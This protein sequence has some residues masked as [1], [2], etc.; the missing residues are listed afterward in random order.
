M[1]PE[2]LTTALHYANAGIP[3]FPC[4]PNKAPATASGFKD[5]TTYPEQIRNWFESGDYLLGIPTG[6]IGCIDV[7]D[8]P[9]AEAFEGELF[10]AKIHALVRQKTPSGG[11]HFLFKS[12]GEPIKNMK[13]ARAKEGGKSGLL[14]ET[15]GIGGYICTGGGYEWERGDLTQLT[16]L[17]SEQLEDVLSAARSFDKLPKEKKPSLKMHDDTTPG[18]DYNRRGDWQSLLMSHGW[19]QAGG[20]RWRRPGKASGVSADWIPDANIFHVFSS[21]AEPLEGGNSYSPFALFTFLE[22]NGNFSEAAKELARQGYGSR[23][24]QDIGKSIDADQKVP[25]AIYYETKS[26]R[27]WIEDSKGRFRSYPERHAV[28]VLQAAGF[29]RAKDIDEITPVLF[30]ARC[31][32]PFDLALNISGMPKGLHQINSLDIL[33]PEGARL[34]EPSPGT[35]KTLETVFRNALEE[36]QWK[37]FYWWTA[38][39]L[40]GLYAG[41]WVPAQVIAL[42]GETGACKSLTQQI[43]TRMFGGSE[44]RII[45]G[46]TGATS[47]NGDWATAT[48]L[49]VEDDFSDNSKS[50]RQR[51]KETVKA[52]AVNEYHRI[53]PKGAQA[54]S[55]R[56]FW[57]MTLSCNPVEESLA[58]LPEIDESVAGKLSLLWCRRASMPMPTDSPPA[59]K[60]FWNQLCIELPCMIDEML[61]A[62]EVPEDLRD[63]EGRCCVKAYH[64]PKAREA[65]EALSPDGQMLGQITEVIDEP[66]WEGTAKDLWNLLDNENAAGRYQPKGIGR[67]LGRLATTHPSRVTTLRTDRRG[68][69][70]YRITQLSEC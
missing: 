17:T 22:H 6:E 53:H 20:T 64:H 1:N 39:T 3:V 56:P 25:P 37:W 47:F 28:A 65:V 49:V 67:L 52:V 44:A 58:V 68:V 61:K 33:V 19:T 55:I 42:I 34:I 59:R 8:E 60:A 29:V 54:I 46:M 30:E 4:K 38:S 15:R 51:I 11:A 40:Q 50:I 63:P 16:T 7:E 9:T 70:I 69:C 21:N 32:R 23:I 5:A 36:D 18:D 24:K 43:I 13:L 31:E 48:H 27:Y 14:I 66:T 12:E 26:A 45:Q 57:R 10:K 41:S 2:T 35:W 62:G